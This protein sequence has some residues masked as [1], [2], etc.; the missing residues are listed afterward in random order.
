MPITRQTRKPVVDLS[1][2]DLEYFPIWEFATDEEL[3]V[4]DETWVRPVPRKTIPTNAYSQIV[5]AEFQT[6]SGKNCQGFMVVTTAGAAVEIDP[7][8]IIL[9]EYLVLPRAS[10]TEAEREGH[11]CSLNNRI[12]LADALQS[13]ETEVFPLEFHLKVAIAGENVKRTGFV[14]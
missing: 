4:G 1:L 10:R 11:A 13:A 7:G 8:A 14:E 2:T 3:K 9:G 5:A 6:A 12:K